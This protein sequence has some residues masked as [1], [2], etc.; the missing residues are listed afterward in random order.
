MYQRQQGRQSKPAGTCRSTS[1]EGANKLVDVAQTFPHTP[2][3]LCLL[4]YFNPSFLQQLS[5]N[6]IQFCCGAWRAPPTKGFSL[7]IPFAPHHQVV[8]RVTSDGEARMPRRRGRACR[9]VAD[10]RVEISQQ[11]LHT[12]ASSSRPTAAGPPSK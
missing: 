10:W 7:S 3:N 4:Y 1:S 8:R 9:L 11:G 2:A 5:R 6:E 12:A